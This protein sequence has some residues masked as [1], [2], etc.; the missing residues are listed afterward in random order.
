MSNQDQVSGMVKISMPWP[1]RKLS[2]NARAHWAEKAKITKSYKYHCYIEARLAGVK[3][4]KAAYVEISMTFCP[5]DARRRDLDNVFASSKAM[6]DGIALALGV[7]DHKFMFWQQ[8]GGKTPGGA[9][10]V[11]LKYY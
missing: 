6:I 4:I 9:V 5:P 10:I 3:P 1:P 8:W 2:P 7:D 11:T